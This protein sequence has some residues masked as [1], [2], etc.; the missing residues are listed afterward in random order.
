MSDDAVDVRYEAANI[1]AQVTDDLAVL[2]MVTDL[3][4][5]AVHMR[6]SVLQ[7]LYAELRQA[8][9]PTAAPVDSL[10]SGAV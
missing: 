1:T 8:L 4:R 7:G 3:G 6:Q 5:V 10:A 2:V 9:E